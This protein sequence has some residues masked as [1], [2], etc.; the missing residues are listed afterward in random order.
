MKMILERLLRSSRYYV[1]EQINAILCG[2]VGEIER[3]E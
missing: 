1:N 2:N 3:T